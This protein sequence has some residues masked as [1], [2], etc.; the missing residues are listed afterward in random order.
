MTSE[1]CRESKAGKPS[2]FF[3]LTMHL[4][5]LNKLNMFTE[6][7]SFEVLPEGRISVKSVPLHLPYC[8]NKMMRKSLTTK[9]GHNVDDDDWG[10]D[11]VK[12][13]TR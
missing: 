12:M 9:K 13:Q 10:D 6:V 8:R 5:K 4:S 7:L 1:S 2:V 11:V 3:T